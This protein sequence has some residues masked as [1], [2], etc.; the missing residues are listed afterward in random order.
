MYKLKKTKTVIRTNSPAS[1]MEFPGYH[2]PKN[3]SSYPTQ[4]EMLEYLHSYADHFDLNK[5]IKLHHQVIHVQPIEND[6]WE[7]TVKDLKMNEFTTNV[8]DA[9]L[10]CNGHFFA[11]HFPS[12]DGINEF[13]GKIMHSHDFRKDEDFRGMFHNFNRFQMRRS[14]NIIIF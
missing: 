11:P 1:Q 7:V 13:K 10:V 8:Y 2:H 14:Q 5:F 12:I 9:V 3:V 6:K 4:A